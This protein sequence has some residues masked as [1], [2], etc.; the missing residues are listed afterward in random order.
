VIKHGEP[1]YL[2]CSSQGD[3]RFSAFYARPDS[4]GGKSIEKAYQAMKVFEDGS[5]GLS[6][7]KAMGK[8]SVN[9][10][11]CEAAYINWWQEWVEQEGLLHILQ[12]ATG[13]SDRFGKF[14]HVCQATVLWNIRNGKY[15][16]V[17]LLH[18]R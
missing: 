4:L 15:T 10:E 18:D 2:E 5:T 11:E 13:L 9:R 1:P 12:A 17:E 8:F 16:Q 7:R 3:K 6:W 14:G